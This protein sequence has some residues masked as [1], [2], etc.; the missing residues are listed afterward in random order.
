MLLSS[1]RKLGSSF[2]F[3]SLILFLQNLSHCCSFLSMSMFSFP[4]LQAGVLGTTSVA[5]TSMMFLMTSSVVI[6]TSSLLLSWYKPSV[7]SLDTVL[8]TMFFLPWMCLNLTHYHTALSTQRLHLSVALC[9]GRLWHPWRQGWTSYKTQP[10]IGSTLVL[11]CPWVAPMLLWLPPSLIGAG[12]Y[13]SL[14]E[15]LNSEPEFGKTHT[16]CKWI[17]SQHLVVTWR[18]LWDTAGAPATSQRRPLCH[19]SSWG[20]LSALC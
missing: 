15:N 1:S 5:W 10:N 6:S 13:Q 11:Q 8:V 9:W 12:L 17:L 16:Y 7:L 4:M 3:I 14:Q 2:F 18:L 19:P 20:K